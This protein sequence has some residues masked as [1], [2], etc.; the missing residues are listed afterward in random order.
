MTI[1]KNKI[2]NVL[3]V[4]MRQLP[5]AMTTKECGD[6]DR[7]H[8]HDPPH[9]RRFIVKEYAK[10]MF[11]QEPPAKIGKFYFAALVK[12]LTKAGRM[13]RLDQEVVD[14]IRGLTLC[15]WAA[16]RPVREDVGHLWFPTDSAETYEFRP[17]RAQTRGERPKHMRNLSLELDLLD[18][19]ARVCDALAEIGVSVP[20]MI[21]TVRKE[22]DRQRFWR[23]VEAAGGGKQPMPAQ[24][25]L[26]DVNGEPIA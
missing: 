16:K 26:V 6:P 19:P 12:G 9:I 2:S 25:V 14:W 8:K 5:E 18:W 4:D 23:A 24:S 20:D 21:S 13:K 15:G 22:M 10:R 1:V 3:P 11:K 17:G 7:I